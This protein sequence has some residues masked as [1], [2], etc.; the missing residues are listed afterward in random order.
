MQI[1]IIKFGEATQFA[2]LPEGTTLGQAI[3]GALDN[4]SVVL[5]ASSM[6]FR[7]NGVNADND[8]VLEDGD[9]LTAQPPS[10]KG[11]M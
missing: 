9:L 5:D 3:D 2:N 8:T 4:L 11:G 10:I 7:I 1:R 6:T